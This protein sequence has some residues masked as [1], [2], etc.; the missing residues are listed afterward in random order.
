M[1][2]KTQKVLMVVYM[3]IS[4]LTIITLL[5]VDLYINVSNNQAL[6][7]PVSAI[8]LLDMVGTNIENFTP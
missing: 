4:T 7:N 8:L 5:S 2:K 6:Q 1:D 3:I